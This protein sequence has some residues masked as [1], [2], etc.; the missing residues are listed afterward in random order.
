MRI[1]FVTCTLALITMACEP[2][3]GSVVGT[4]TVTMSLDQNACGERA[5]HSL[6]GSRYSAE[7]RTDE[8]DAYWRIP[9]QTPLRG[10]VEAPD[11][12]FDY[13]AV[14]AADTPDGGP[15][16][17]LV[18]TEVLR[19]QVDN[20]AAGPD[21]GS[22]A[23]PPPTTDTDERPTLRGEHVFTVSPE[24]AG[25]CQHAIA[26]AGAF[27]ALPCTLHYTLHGTSRKPF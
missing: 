21:A 19:V 24:V 12:R 3:P 16:C 9:A 1:F 17:R 13:A 4:F 10:R 14:V 8:H 23:A 5:V 22:P 11:Y 7:L 6:D 15:G 27:E 25:T 2:L 26:P 18:Q 20:V